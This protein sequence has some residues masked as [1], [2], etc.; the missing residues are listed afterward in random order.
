MKNFNLNFKSIVQSKA[1]W[2]LTIIAIVTLVVG[3]MWANYNC[4]WYGN[5]FFRAPDNW[6]LS[7][8]KVILPLLLDHQRENRHLFVL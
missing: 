6:D 5:V 3:Q 2:L 1:R 8:N 4:N 7:T